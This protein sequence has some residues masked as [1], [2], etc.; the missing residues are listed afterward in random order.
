MIGTRR[1]TAHPDRTD[2]FLTGVVQGESAAEH[3]HSTDPMA[4]QGVVRVSEG[5]RVALSACIRESTSKSCVAG[6][7]RT[8]I[9]RRTT[10][11]KA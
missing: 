3:V 4:D 6:K 1:I 7:A 10:A 11:L 9:R 8:Q 2:E 5:T